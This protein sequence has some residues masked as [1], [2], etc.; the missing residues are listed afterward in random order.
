MSSNAEYN[1]LFP[2]VTNPEN[3]KKYE[4]FYLWAFIA[5][6]TRFYGSEFTNMSGTFIPFLDC[7]NHSQDALTT[8][9]TKD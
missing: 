9:L 3:K 8:Y 1:E 6:T 7:I 2:G 4:D 5:C